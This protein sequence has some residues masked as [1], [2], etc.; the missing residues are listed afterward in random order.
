MK[1][2]WK[3]HPLSE[4]WGDL[5]EDEFSD[6]V[7]DV[8]ANGVHEAIMRHPDGRVLD[9]WHRYRAALLA[10]KNP[11]DLVLP[12]TQDPVAY[13]IGKNARRRHLTTAQRTACILAAKEWA[14]PGRPSKETN[15]KAMTRK[16]IADLAGASVGTVSEV[17]R[18]VVEGHGEAVRA[19]EETPHSLRQKRE[20]VRQEDEEF[21]PITRIEKL[22]AKTETL[23]EEKKHLQDEVATVREDMETLQ[24]QLE[25]SEKNAQPYDVTHARADG[26]EKSIARLQTELEQCR[27]RSD[28][29]FKQY[30]AEQAETADL[31]EQIEKLQEAGA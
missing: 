9:G 11:P 19:G 20:A 8:R 1:K 25:Q 28:F 27:G 12:A 30:K 18:A 16:E 22:I 23:G 13:V 24:E 14:P 31:R 4:V 17:K 21:E 26:L 6:L 5:P 7:E 10:G 3:R 15:R 2:N 29:W